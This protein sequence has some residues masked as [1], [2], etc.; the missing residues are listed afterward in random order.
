MSYKTIAVHLDDDPR[1]PDRIALAADLAR[2]FQG[3]VVGIA[4]IGVPDVILTLN[5]TVP[6]GVELVALSMAH[7][8]TRA[9]ASAQAFAAQCKP[10][11]I[12]FESRVVGAE[13]LDAM[14]EHGRCS[15]LIVVGQTDRNR[16]AGGVAFDLLP[17]VLLHMGPPV[18]VVPY[19]G[20]FTSIGHHALVAWKN[21]SEAAD[22]LRSALPLLCT[23]RRVSLVEIV[24]TRTVPAD[25][26]SLQL[27]TAWLKSHGI[28][29]EGHREIDLAGVGDQL[30]SRA[31]EIG[32]DLIVSGAYGHSRLRE[33]VLGGVTRHL[34]E[35]MTL[36]TLFSH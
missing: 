23:G 25:F 34:L 8:R 26:D 29:C 20:V 19:A 13:A 4:P 9:E 16:A 32:A 31:S 33:W 10:L 35:H 11:D 12:A 24:S 27:A 2:R 21:T 15:D 28:A 5:S 1:C 18:L 36:P 14:V 22:A 30:L 3:R 17:Q 7:L 6:D